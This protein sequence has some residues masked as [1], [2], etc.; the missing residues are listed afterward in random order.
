MEEPPRTDAP[1]PL[2]PPAIELERAIGYNCGYGNCCSSTSSADIFYALGGNVVRQTES[3]DGVEQQLIR[4]TED[5]LTLLKLSDSGKILVTV[6]GGGV[7]PDAI[8]WN[9]QTNKILFRLT[10]HE[11]GIAAV[12]ISSDEKLLLTVGNT[13][14]RRII[15]TDTS[16][17]QLVNQTVLPK[18]DDNPVVTSAV[19]GGQIEDLKRRKTDY[20]QFSVLSGQRAYRYKFNPKTVEN[21]TQERTSVGNVVRNWTS[22]VYSHPGDLL[23]LGSDSGDVAVVSVHDSVICSTEKL[24]KSS[25]RYLTLAPPEQKSAA[26]NNEIMFQYARFGD[27][28]RRSS[29]IFVGGNCGTVLIL[30]IQDHCN[31]SFTVTTKFQLNAPVR[32]ISNL[33]NGELLCGTNKGDICKATPSP[34]SGTGRAA[35]NWSQVVSAPYGAVKCLAFQ[36]PECSDKVISGSSDGVVRV[37]DLSTYRIICNGV[38]RQHKVNSP[39]CIAAVGNTDTCITGW[40]DGGI[41]CFD[42][43]DGELHWELPNS[44]QGACTHVVVAEN[45][46]FFVTSGEHGE[47]KIWNMRTHQMTTELKEHRGRITTLELFKDGVHLLSTGHDKSLMVW[48]LNTGERAVTNVLPMGQINSGFIVKN[49]SSVV[50]TGTD[51]KISLWDLRQHEPTH[52]VPLGTKFDDITTTTISPSHSGQFF[53]TGGTNQV[54]TLWDQSTLRPLQSGVAHTASINQVL[55][56]PDDRQLLSCS[57]DQS[58]V[59]WNF[60]T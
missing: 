7:S 12:D 11:S 43:S 49:Q 53:A 6:Q 51:R 40:A 54:V 14:D 28:A 42:T 8:C 44:H 37:W 50:T 41:R 5:R 30:R 35:Y 47:I 13:E 55:F 31:I 52:Q 58:I 26:E 60:Y 59:V 32:S 3:E 20:Y 22:A 23:F 10:E 18:T 29:T 38:Q 15:I 39:L 27:H 4:G 2:P 24:L 17:G 45:L 48:D 56:S 46:A 1:N 33:P 9:V 25:I 19:W 57:E 36:S 16:T 21:I 34:E